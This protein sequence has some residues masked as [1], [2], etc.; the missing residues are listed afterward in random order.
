MGL[1]RDSEDEET[2]R[3]CG[4]AGGNEVA[5]AAGW[6]HTEAHEHQGYLC[7]V[8]ILYLLKT[9][10]KGDFCTIVAQMPGNLPPA[11]HGAQKEQY[12][13]MYKAWQILGQEVLEGGQPL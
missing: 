3:R 12:T 11:C 10:E 9:T 5:M 2:Q 4:K 1:L 7:P 6:Q 13:S 8:W